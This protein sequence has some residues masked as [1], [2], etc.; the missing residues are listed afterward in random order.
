MA[1]KKDEPLRPDP[2]RTWPWPTTNGL[3]LIEGGGGIQIAQIFQL[4][5]ARTQPRHFLLQAVQRGFAGG[6]LVTVGIFAVFHQMNE[7]RHSRT[8][9]RS[10]PTGA[11]AARSKTKGS[12]G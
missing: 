7:G 8:A 11:T 10:V 4:L 1:A 6:F 9:Q 2:A 3:P 12:L 5:D